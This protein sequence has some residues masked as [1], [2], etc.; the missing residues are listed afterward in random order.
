MA[1]DQ[2]I[3]RRWSIDHI[4]REVPH[5]FGWA[6]GG[7]DIITKALSCID[8]DLHARTWQVL[9]EV[10]WVF[11]ILASEIMQIP[12]PYFSWQAQ[13]WAELR[14]NETDRDRWGRGI[15]YLRALFLSSGLIFNHGYEYASN[16]SFLVLWSRSAPTVHYRGIQSVL[17]VPGELQRL[18][19]A[20]H[21]SAGG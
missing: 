8:T 2:G 19:R 3:I 20:S 12:G 18:Q 21:T 14:E 16:D 9:R 4:A 6:D 7:W 15:S 1:S 11:S 10:S 13:R 17:N 5:P